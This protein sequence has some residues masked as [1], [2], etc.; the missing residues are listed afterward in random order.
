M[1]L[2]YA[3]RTRQAAG[4]WHVRNMFLSR[5][6][7]HPGGRRTEV[8]AVAGDRPLSKSTAHTLGPCGTLTTTTSDV[9]VQGGRA[10]AETLGDARRDTLLER[11]G[12]GIRRGLSDTNSKVPSTQPRHGHQG[13]VSRTDCGERGLVWCPPLGR[14]YTRGGY[15]G[16]HGAPT[17]S[18]PLQARDKLG[19]A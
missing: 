14:R 10:A 6:Q 15:Q 13:L 7:G 17:V 5:Y 18:S 3:L 12:S 2:L 1:S 19:T 4:Q 9:T 16:S 8:V 11:G